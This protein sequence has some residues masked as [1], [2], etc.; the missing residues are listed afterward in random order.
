[1]RTLLEEKRYLIALIKVNVH[2]GIFHTFVAKTEG[3]SLEAF[4]FLEDLGYTISDVGSSIKV[5]WSIID[6][7]KTKT[8]TKK[9]PSKKTKRKP[10]KK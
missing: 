4:A 2:L 5:D 7:G 9:S 3:I 1:M 10:K 6:N 8:T